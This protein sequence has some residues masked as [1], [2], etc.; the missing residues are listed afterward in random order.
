MT[1]YVIKKQQKL[2]SFLKIVGYLPFPVVGI[3]F[4]R[5]SHRTDCS[6]TVITVMYFDN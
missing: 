2:Q 4:A 1:K 6:H 5:T 3:T